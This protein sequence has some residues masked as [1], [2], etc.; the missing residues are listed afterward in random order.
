MININL[1]SCSK[2]PFYPNWN[3]KR[4]PEDKYNICFNSSE[5]LDWDCVVVCQDVPETKMFKCRQ[6]NVIYVSGEPPLMFPCPKSFTKQFDFILVSDPSVKHPNRLLHHG[7]LSWKLGLGYKSKQHRYDYDALANLEP[8]KTK[9]ISLVSSNLMMMPG[10]NKRMSI[11]EKLK[12]DYPN[13]ID[14]FGRGFEFVDYKADAL[15]PYRF[16]ICIENS[17]I[18]YYWTEK[19][20]DPILAQCVPIYS[21]CTDISNYFGYDG[22]FTFDVNNYDSLKIIIDRIIKNPDEEY[23]QKKEALENMRHVL[24]EKENIIPYCVEYVQSHPK[25]AIKEYTI[26]RLSDNSEYAWQFFIIRAKR[27]AYNSYFRLKNS[28]FSK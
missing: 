2:A 23:N 19:I 16:H 18:P 22:Y 11:I 5:D 26:K 25:N 3:K 10:H 9:L 13:E 21:G 1:L 17:S 15:L 28:L 12:N 24:M 14:I 20:S 4:Y 7:F 27:F 6:G 8:K